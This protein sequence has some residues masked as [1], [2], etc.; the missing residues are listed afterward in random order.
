MHKWSKMRLEI[1]EEIFH[2]VFLCSFVR[3]SA[4]QINHER[5]HSG[6]LNIWKWVTEWEKERERKKWEKMQKKNSKSPV[7]R[8]ASLSVVSL[9]FVE[10]I[11]FC[12]KN[13]KKKKKETMTTKICI[14][15]TDVVFNQ[16]RNATDSMCECVCELFNRIRSQI[17]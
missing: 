10:I 11:L 1:Y 12:A 5:M 13:K 14:K 9:I 16:K 2:F 4:G 7:R 15:S 6:T 17:G 3:F 8:N